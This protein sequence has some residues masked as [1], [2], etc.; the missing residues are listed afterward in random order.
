[1]LIMYTSQCMANR[2]DSLIATLPTITNDSTRLEMLHTITLSLQH[3]P[4]QEEY[5][6]QMIAEAHRLHHEEKECIGIYLLM[7]YYYNNYDDTDS[8]ELWQRQLKPIA[9]KIKDYRDYFDAKKLII[10]NHVYSRHYELAINEAKAMAE[11]AEQYNYMDGMASAYLCLANAYC[12]TRQLGNEYEALMKIYNRL[13]DFHH[14]NTKAGTLELLIEYAFHSKLH[15]NMNEYLDAYE[16]LLN[17]QK[18]P[19]RLSEDVYRFHRLYAVL[20]RIYLYSQTK[21]YE[22]AKRYVA[23]A[24]RFG[25]EVEMHPYQVLALYAQQT[26]Y[27]AIDQPQHALALNDSTAQILQGNELYE[28]FIQRQLRYRGNI[29]YK[30]ARFEEAVQCY[31]RYRQV[32]DSDEQVISE[33]QLEEFQRQRHRDEL[34]LKQSQLKELTVWLLLSIALILIGS[35]FFY[36][37]HIQRLRLELKE[38]KRETREQTIYAQRANEMKGIFLNDLRQHISKPIHTVISLSQSLT[39][40]TTLTDSQ[41]RKTCETIQLKTQQL[42]RLV[43]SVLDLSRLEAGM[44]K[45]Q[46][47]D[48]DLC[49]ILNQAIDEVS[50][51][52]PEVTIT[53]SEKLPEVIIN[54][55]SKRLMQLF[56]SCLVVPS[57]PPPSSLSIQVEVGKKSVKINI[58]HSPLADVKNTCE[59]TT[60]RHEINRLT[61]QYFH[62]TY[63]ISP[64]DASIPWIEITYPFDLR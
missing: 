29:L 42:I 61:I 7:L 48:C 38:S 36:Y 30:M 58:L 14:F 19:K 25:H 18:S 41:R 64:N 6:R 20:F 55:D 56:S 32:N 35:F 21:E 49:T 34:L 26:Y 45:W 47:G 3:T 31:E 22:K 24:K 17:E 43:T 46:L 62:G 1:M 44:T 9:L 52:H 8:L 60:I 57:T 13:E 2:V 4:R 50:L 12:E 53:R 27:L 51:H 11:E 40:S 15:S 28:T 63:K 59:E 10:N 54:S 37:R 16:A 39:H 33:L 23:E 5:A